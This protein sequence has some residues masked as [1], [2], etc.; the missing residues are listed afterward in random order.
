MVRIARPGPSEARSAASPA[1]QVA[2]EVVHRV[3][4]GAYADRVLR[5][6]AARAGLA[7]IDRAFAQHLAY[8]TVQRRRTLDYVIAALSARPLHM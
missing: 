8:G 5:A 7:G 3:T 1:R 2:Y 6:E 4:D